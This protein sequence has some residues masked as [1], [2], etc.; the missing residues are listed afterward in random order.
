MLG[1]QA[2]QKLLQ[3]TGPHQIK[4]QIGGHLL[5]FCGPIQI[6][7]LGGNKFFITFINDCSRKIWAYLL[8]RKSEVFEV[9]VKFKSLVEKQSGL[10]IKILRTDGGEEFVFDQFQVF[11]EKEGIVHEVA[12]PYTP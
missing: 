4:R 5:R 6:D 3:P 2:S 7:S 12:P 9:F 8:K 10:C 11:C 1:V